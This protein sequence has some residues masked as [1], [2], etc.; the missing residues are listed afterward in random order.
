MQE[1]SRRGVCSVFYAPV[2]ATLIAGRGL[3]LPG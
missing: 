2:L 3:L 1:P